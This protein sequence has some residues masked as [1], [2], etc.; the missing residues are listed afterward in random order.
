VKQAKVERELG[1]GGPSAM[2]DGVL[3]GEEAM[4]PARW[5]GAGGRARGDALLVEEG[6]TAPNKVGGVGVAVF[7]MVVAGGRAGGG[8]D[9]GDITARLDVMVRAEAEGAGAVSSARR[10]GRAASGNIEG[11]AHWV[12]GQAVVEVGVMAGW[13]IGAS[14]ERGQ[15]TGLQRPVRH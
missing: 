3:V 11:G 2:V 14:V 13:L 5:S 12:L 1:G 4:A 10:H 8:R 9:G 7:G 6:G 15:G